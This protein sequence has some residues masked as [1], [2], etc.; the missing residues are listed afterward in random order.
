MSHVSYRLHDPNDITH[1]SSVILAYCVFVHS[2]IRACLSD[3]PDMYSARTFVCENVQK[4][5]EAEYT[6]KK[7]ETYGIHN[8]KYFCVMCYDNKNMKCIC[9]M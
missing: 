8:I 3:I 2:F 9:K 1:T 4:K 5:K 7:K 6:K